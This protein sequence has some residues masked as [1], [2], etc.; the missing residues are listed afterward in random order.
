MKNILKNRSALSAVVSTLIVLVISVLLATVVT[1][2]A[3]NVVSTRVQQEDLSITMQHV[4]YDSSSKTS[5]AALLIVNSGGKDVVITKIQVRGQT[6]QLN[7][8]FYVSGPFPVPSDL[9]Y[10][11][12][13]ADSAPTYINTGEGTYRDLSTTTNDLV[14]KSGNMMAVYINDPDSIIINDVGTTVSIN[15]FTADTMFYKETNVQGSAP[16]QAQAQQL[17]ASSV[18]VSNDNIHAWYDGIGNQVGMV[19]TNGGTGAV[20]ITEVVVNGNNGVGTMYDYVGSLT[21]GP[22][23]QWISGAGFTS[24]Q[25]QGHLLTRVT[26]CVIPAGQTAIIYVAPEWSLGSFGDDS[27]VGQTI[28]ISFAIQ[29]YSALTQEVTV[30]NAA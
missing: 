21:V 8:V 28:E 5:E 18:T 1:Y 30:Q 6:A 23:L 14:L 16:G 22:S 19:L 24:T 15:V 13:L 11:S 4:W 3:V 29:G 27:L 25:I 17:L 20:T 26:E 7:D 12:T 2:Y 10:L 9:Y